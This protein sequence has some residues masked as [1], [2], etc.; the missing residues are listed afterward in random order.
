MPREMPSAPSAGA[1]SERSPIDSQDTAPVEARSDP[2]LRDHS[3]PRADAELRGAAELR[4]HPELRGAPELRRDAAVC[5][6]PELRAG[7]EMH[8]P[9]ERA[10]PAVAE[11]SS[12]PRRSLALTEPID[13]ALMEAAVRRRRAAR[14]ARAREFG[15]S[16]YW[17]RLQT[18][19][20]TVNPVSIGTL[21]IALAVVSLALVTRGA[22]MARHAPAASAT[23]AKI[24]APPG[25]A[26]EVSRASAAL[27]ESKS[28]AL[29]AVRESAA[30][31]TS[32][33]PSN[34]GRPAQ[35]LTSSARA[36][37]EERSAA[38]RASGSSVE[39]GSS[40]P[41]W[42]ASEPT[43]AA[44]SGSGN[45]KSSSSPSAA[46]DD[47]ARSNDLDSVDS[48]ADAVYLRSEDVE[49]LRE[50]GDLS[51]SG[52][53]SSASRSARAPR[54]KTKED[55]SPATLHVLPPEPRLID[56]TDPYTP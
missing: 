47:Q 36:G 10:A 16:V 23:G 53:R 6:S 11:A 24:A 9:S 28:S 1:V 34:A 48:D 32:A 52:S 37:S 44:A 12:V 39:P 30:S 20:R 33:L 5:S 3:P 19:A 21:G 4:G 40:A 49:R 56:E 29:A 14:G 43:R 15:W 26:H 35:D 18:W 38:A 46:S 8:A 7:P 55:P 41:R 31:S 50:V 2:A 45:S 25:A 13:P 42:L 51:S 54:A 17:E 22:L 27:L